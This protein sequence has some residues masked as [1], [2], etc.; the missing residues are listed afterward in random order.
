MKPCSWCD[1]EFMATV[2]Y[3]IYCSP[4]CRSEATKIKIANKQVLNKRKKRIGKDRKCARGCGTTLSMYNDSSYCL[5]NSLPATSTVVDTNL[6]VLDEVRDLEQ[7]IAHA[8]FSLLGSSRA[9]THAV[10]KSP[11]LTRFG[12]SPLHMSAANS[13]RG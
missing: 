8:K 4:T 11:K 6:E 9:R 10:C 2:S 12:S 1:N 13:H 3:Q 7:F 5:N